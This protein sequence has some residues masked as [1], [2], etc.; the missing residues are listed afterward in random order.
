MLVAGQGMAD[1]DG[2]AARGIELAIGLVGD[3][4]RAERHAGIELERLVRPELGEQ[5]LRVVR[6]PHPIR[7]RPATDGFQLGH[8]LSQPP[9][10]NECRRRKI[11]QRLKDRERLR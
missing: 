1:Q 6:L 2:V 9:V 5:R 7:Q 11:L 10:R 8:V 3:L 4:E